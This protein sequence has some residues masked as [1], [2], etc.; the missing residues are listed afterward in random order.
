M[1]AFFYYLSASTWKERLLLILV[2][3]RP[4]L[5]PDTLV[6]NMQK[7]ISTTPHGS[8]VKGRSQSPH[9]TRITM[10]SLSPSLSNSTTFHVLWSVHCPLLSSPS[11]AST[12]QCQVEPTSSR[13]GDNTEGWFSNWRLKGPLGCCCEERAG[14]GHVTPLRLISYTPIQNK[15]FFL[16]SGVEPAFSAEKQGAEVR[17]KETG[18]EGNYGHTCSFLNNYIEVWLIFLL[19]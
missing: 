11:M 2:A 15:G 13:W 17:R 4:L 8:Q 7:L 16:D 5:T 1:P 3:A 18:S 14:G 12:T 6:N 19:H 9:T 10:A